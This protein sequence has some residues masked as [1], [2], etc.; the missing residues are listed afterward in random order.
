MVTSILTY[1]KGTKEK[2]ICYGK[3]N[4]NL[5]GYCV[6]DMDGD[7][8]TRK[9]TYHYISTLAG[10]VILWCSRLQR[11]I[12]LSATGA[13]YISAAEASKEAIWFTPLCSEVESQSKFQSYI[14]IT[15]VPYV[16]QRALFT[17]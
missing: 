2:C 14:V 11:I 10:G 17:T 6:S 13:E 3:G 9:S 5:H 4:L 16:W 12:A 8:D 7:V 15:K 1:R